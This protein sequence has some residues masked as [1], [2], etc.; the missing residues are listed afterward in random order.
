MQGVTAPDADVRPVTV[1][2]AEDDPGTREYASAVL[3]DLG[4]RVLRARNGDEALRVWSAHRDQIDVVMTDLLMPLRGGVSVYRT[5][6]RE[7]SE[8]PVIVVSGFPHVAEMLDARYEGVV[9]FLQKPVEPEQF[10]AA[11]RRA[12]VRA[13]A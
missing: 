11:M 7:R 9:E 1:L 3:E 2:L 10:A 6:H 12:L 4:C 13:S 8:V 5:V